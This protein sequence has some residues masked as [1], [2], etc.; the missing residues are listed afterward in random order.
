MQKKIRSIGDIYEIRQCK[1]LNTS[2]MKACKVYRKLELTENSLEL[3]R[4]E[5][6]LLKKLDHPNIIKIHNVI[7]DVDRIYLII[8]DIR[9]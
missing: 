6:E 9:G 3:I 4:R 7:E 2:E 8:D 5:I 1:D